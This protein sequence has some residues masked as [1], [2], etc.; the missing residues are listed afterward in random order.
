MTYSTEP[1]TT[2]QI[3]AGAPFDNC[4]LCGKDFPACTCTPQQRLDAVLIAA[5]FDAYVAELRARNAKLAPR[6][7]KP[8][9]YHT[10]GWTA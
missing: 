8:L 9:A 4:E 10:K 3:H 5:E 1:T 6:D 2:A 7:S